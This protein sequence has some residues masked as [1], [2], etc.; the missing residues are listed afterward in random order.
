M[1]G[2]CLEPAAQ[3]RA[4]TKDENEEK[5]PGRSLF[6]VNLAETDANDDYQPVGRKNERCIQGHAIWFKGRS[7]EIA[8]KK[9]GILIGVV[10]RNF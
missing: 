1:V 9:D 8:G 2:R 7:C 10:I 6:S 3:S 5:D 4:Q